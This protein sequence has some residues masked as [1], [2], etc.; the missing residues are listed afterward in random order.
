MELS[1]VGKT[2]EFV[3]FNDDDDEDANCIILFKV[4]KM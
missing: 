4:D 2:R 1:L 3:C